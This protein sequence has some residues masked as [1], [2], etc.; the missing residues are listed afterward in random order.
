MYFDLHYQYDQKPQLFVG[1][2][3][4]VEQRLE[5]GKVPDQLEDPENPHHPDEPHDLSGLAQDLEVLQALHQGRDEVGKN[6]QEVDLKRP[7]YD[8]GLF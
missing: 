3:E 4:C 8:L 1:L 2:L 7:K 6:C 5:P